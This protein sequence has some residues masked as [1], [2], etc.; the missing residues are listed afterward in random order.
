MGDGV[1][2][3]GDVVRGRQRQ[4]A[5]YLWLLLLLLLEVLPRA[6]RVGLPL[7]TGVLGGWMGRVGVVDSP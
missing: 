1:Q 3:W 5:C 4:D 2:G 6:A 7:L